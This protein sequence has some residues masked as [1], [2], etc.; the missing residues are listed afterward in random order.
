MLRPAAIAFLSYLTGSVNV[1]YLTG[2]LLKGI[3]LR[4]HGSGNIGASNVWQS[5]WKP[6]VVPVGLAEIGQGYAGPALARATGA[7]EGAQALAGVLVVAGH[8]WSPLL[9]FAGG[10]GVSTA[11]GVMLAISKPALV[12]FTALAL[13][14][15][16]TKKVPQLVG[17][18]VVAAPI[19]ALAAGQRT[20]AV[21]GLG[22]VAALVFAKR[23][24]GNAPPRAGSDRPRVLLNRLLYDR[25][26]REREAWV[27][28][29]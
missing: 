17:L 15:V 4:E 6:A 27:E 19:A 9:G 13:L 8:N 25:D 29:D 14:G 16:V 18:G 22:G 26:T 20:P 3:D 2:R 11:I 12:A 10:R 7:G 28:R 5:V 24:L 21:A 1:A 23:L